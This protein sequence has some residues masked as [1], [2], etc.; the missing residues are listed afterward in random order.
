MSNLKCLLLA[1]LVVVFFFVSNVLKAECSFD[2]DVQV[3]QHATCP[4]NGI[5][6]VIFK[7]KDGVKLSNSTIKLHCIGG[8]NNQS[9]DGPKDTIQ[10]TAL[11]PCE[12][13]IEAEAIC[14]NSTIGKTDTVIV[15]DKY[16]PLIRSSVNLISID[17]SLRCEAT[18]SVCVKVSG[19]KPPYTVTIDPANDND[20]TEFTF[21]SETYCIPRLNAGFYSF[22]IS[23]S[24]GSG[25]TNMSFQIPVDSFSISA[26]DVN[27]SLKC[28][29]TGSFNLAMKGGD[30][31]SDVTV[32]INCKP[33]TYW[34]LTTFGP[35][36]KNGLLPLQ[37]LPAG[38]YCLTASDGCNTSAIDVIIDTIQTDFPKT[39]YT[40]FNCGESYNWKFDSSEEWE[41]QLLDS[42]GEPINGDTSSSTTRRLEYGKKYKFTAVSVLCKDPFYE[43]IDIPIPG[44]NL[45]INKSEA[46]GTSCSNYKF[47]FF[48]NSDWNKCGYQWEII[49]NSNSVPIAQGSTFP[50]SVL[51]KCDSAYTVVIK[52]RDGE[53]TSEPQKRNCEKPV[54]E[55]FSYS[56]YCYGFI[57][58]MGKF[59]EGTYIDFNKKPVRIDKYQEYLRFP[60]S[61]I[62]VGDNIFE[63]PNQCDDDTTTIIVPYKSAEVVVDTFY[64]T[65]DMDC[66]S[67]RARICPQ[68]K[69]YVDGVAIPLQFGMYERGSDNCDTYSFI[70][71]DHCFYIPQDRD[72]IFT[73]GLVDSTR[74][75][76]N[77]NVCNDARCIIISSLEVKYKKEILSVKDLSQGKTPCGQGY[78]YVE[79]GGGIPPYGYELY[80]NGMF[81]KNNKTG[82][83]NKLDT[84]DTDRYE[85]VI[86]D[87]YGTIIRTDP[88]EI[89]PLSPLEICS[90]SVFCANTNATIEAC[91]IRGATYT[92]KK[93]SNISNLSDSHILEIPDA[94]PKDSGDYTVSMQF[95]DCD[96]IISKTVHVTINPVKRDTFEVSI[97]KGDSYEFNGVLYSTK[98]FYSDTLST[99]LCDSIVTLH[100]T[101]NPTY[102]LTDTITICENKL[103][104]PYGDS[105]FTEAGTKVVHFKTIHS[106]DSV[107]TVTLI[108]NPTYDLTDTI[109][110]CDN[111]LPYKFRDITFP[112]GTVSDD[113]VFHRKT[114]NN[115]DSIVTLHLTVNPSYSSDTTITICSNELDYHF[116]DSIFT[117]AGTKVVHFKTIH[118][119]DS[120][121]TV[122][123]NVNPSY[124][125][126]SMIVICQSDLP[127]EFQ[128][129]IFQPGTVSD[130]YVFHRKTINNCDSIVTLYLTVNPIYDTTI[131]ICS[132]KLD[133]HF[134]DSLFTEAETKVV[135][136][137]TIHLCDS[138]ITVIVVEAPSSAVWIRK[139]ICTGQHYYFNGQ[140]YRKSGIYT[141]TLTDSMN[142]D[143]VTILDLEVTDCPCP[144]IEIP[145]SF[146]PNVDHL[147]DKWE[148]KNINCHEHIVEIFDRFGKLLYRWENNFNGWDGNYLDR[149]MPSTDY[150]YRVILN[151]KRARAGHFTL[152]R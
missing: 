124:D 93:G 30:K 125:L 112:I 12:Y 135:H 127:F 143:S 16:P 89:P 128:D 90:N 61:D 62:I 71:S 31:T 45:Q 34:G 104:Y 84:K 142:C 141:E 98:G 116:G 64:Y 2:L 65:T 108:V 94:T 76:L 33:D 129:T 25:I 52:G 22:T 91:L 4:A 85:V 136:F 7:G 14:N 97:C 139:N 24:C 86:T 106:C 56:D 149:P 109:I 18:G 43:D 42:N 92:W 38:K 111:E 50:A 60:A 99:T 95:E 130:D 41:W 113:Y 132:S 69:V 107:V 115:C 46:V 83:F 49:P 78:V 59:Y 40:D 67:G 138:I 47:N 77:G 148:I 150:W 13:V 110:I 29:P 1:V 28:R 5:I 68:A 8:G 75:P 32:N 27:K 82:E 19:G 23:D 66:S 118:L 74:A 102:D 72:T 152:L 73:I 121:I 20:Q 137:K 114:I 100:L 10:F 6:Q 140:E 81:F 119:C 122:T 87:C 57:R 48:I 133:F 117:E 51:L 70:Q 17:S 39:S 96:S 15:L 105:L 101:V 147:N 35:Y 11:P 54:F 146:T 58:V 103:P 80:K 88:F 3:I 126:D 36:K 134:G 37:Y 9:Y 120:I 53:I 26:Q 123:L 79:A 145:I 151:G 131:T 63:I 144:E 55:T 21:G 44:N